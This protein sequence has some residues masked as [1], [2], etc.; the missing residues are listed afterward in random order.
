MNSRLV[1]TALIVLLI[2]GFAVYTLTRPSVQEPTNQNSTTTVATSTPATNTKTYSSAE[3]D[4]S[5]TYPSSYV[6]SEQDA[7][8]SAQRAHH[9]IT[10][11]RA[12]D[13]PA[14]EGGEGP[15]AITI[16]IFQNTLDSQSAREWITNTSNS[17]YKLGDGTISSTTIGSRDALS[18]RWSGLY[19]GTSVVTATDD[20]VYMFSV[21]YMEMGAPIVQDFV[22]IRN[23]AQIA[24]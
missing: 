22:A 2:A 15:P 20:W 13:L 16:D 5:F 1:I 14:P 17:N 9:T 7:P 12:E 10:L 4:I 3:Y 23:S 8:G 6:L 19:E 18:Y 11:I 21:T 24:Q